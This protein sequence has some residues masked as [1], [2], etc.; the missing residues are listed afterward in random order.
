LGREVGRVIVGKQ[1]VIELLAVAV[2]C[3]GHVLIEDV[4]GIGKTTLAKTLARCLD[5]AF[6][7]IQFT[8]D[9]LPSDVTGIFF[10]NQKS[11][12][13]EF[14]AGPV[15]AN[16]VLADEINRA[17]PRTQSSVLEAMEERQ[18]TVEGYTSALP[19]PFLVLATQNPVE[20]EGTFP[21]P[22]A[23]LDRFLLRATVGYPSQA[24]EVGILRRFETATPL[25]D[26]RP[27]A[28]ADEVM[29]QIAATRRVHVDDVVAEYVVSLSRATREHSAV[30]LGASPRASLALFRA[31]QAFAALRGRDFVIPDDVK[32]LVEPVLGH[33]LILRQQGRLHGA[34]AGRV[35]QSIVDSVPV[36]VEPLPGVSAP[37]L[38]SSFP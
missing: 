7:R 3:E 23:E 33:R 1:D 11:G 14:R 34:A 5:C 12:E 17:T 19:R 21:L 29:A 22:E 13:F 24:E 6:S 26:V 36:P 27:V 31:S 30:E 37:G 32:R 28:T 8:P 20:L 16:V 38:E 4:P 15:H 9:L 18:V 10:F 25:E 2:L 35:L